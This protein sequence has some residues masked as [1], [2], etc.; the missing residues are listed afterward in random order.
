MT[1]DSGLRVQHDLAGLTRE[2]HFKCLLKL[3]HWEFMSHGNT[4]I[5]P[6]TEEGVEL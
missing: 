4:D 2:Q 1:M 5:N 6:E 3:T